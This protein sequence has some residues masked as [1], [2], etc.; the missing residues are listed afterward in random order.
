[1]G[2]PRRVSHIK[3]ERTSFPVRFGVQ[4]PLTVP[5]LH[6]SLSLDTPMASARGR[7]LFFIAVDL[8]Q[9]TNE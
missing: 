4:H 5:R 9:C 7:R 1:V 6:P 2:I 3:W 8:C